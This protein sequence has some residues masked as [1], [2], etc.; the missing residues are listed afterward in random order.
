[1][2]IA[3]LSAT[4]RHVGGGET[5]LAT[6]AADLDAAGHQVALLYG[7][8]EPEARK[9]I[10]LPAG[11]PEWSVDAAVLDA[12]LAALRQWRADAVISNGLLDAAVERRIATQV[13]SVYVAHSYQGTCISGHKAHATP[14]PTPCAKRFGPGCMA[15][16]FPRR[17]GGRSPITM[18]RQYARQRERLETLAA[19]DRIVTLSQHIRR[20]YVN[21]GFVKDAV[22]LLR[23]PV[24]AGGLGEVRQHAIR[25]GD[26]PWRLTFAGRLEWQKG[27][28]VLLD[29]VALLASEGQRMQV[30]VAGDGP[31]CED[32][33][34][35]A[36]TLPAHARVEFPGW[37]D[38]ARM[39]DLYARTDVL[40][41][42]SLWPEPFGLVGPEAGSRGVPAV[43]FRVGG[44]PEW[45][46]NG[47]GGVFA[48]ADP[49]DA[50]SLADAIRQ[51]LSDPHEHARLRAGAREAAARFTRAAHLEGMIELL[52][53]A[54][55]ERAGR[56]TTRTAFIGGEP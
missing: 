18:V 49:P 32:L 29:A 55:S 48:A 56:G 5:Y 8:D 42:P 2:R 34:R 22:V 24:L 17:C 44:I 10:A 27:P 31:D 6:L 50:R 47:A 36:A 30:T 14:V 46:E 13:P 20:E 23:A 37:L 41:V 11:T 7:S 39:H 3:L 45:L 25:R 43:A 54:R 28:Q 21:H 33:I 26:E 53:A 35:Q 16:Y 51:A 40:V 9:P 52:T 1:M 19:Y 4:R 12:S 38:R 15:Y